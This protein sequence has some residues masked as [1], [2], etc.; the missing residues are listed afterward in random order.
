MKV[1]LQIYEIIFGKNRTFRTG[2]VTA[3]VV[4][5]VSR[6]ENHRGSQGLHF[7]GGATASSL[8][9][10][11]VSSEAFASVSE[12]TTGSVSVAAELS[13]DASSVSYTNQK[14]KVL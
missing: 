1:F 14:K 13:L 11:G 4:K 8:S 12:A 7:E 6:Q 5:I 10:A 9:T 2:V 3:V